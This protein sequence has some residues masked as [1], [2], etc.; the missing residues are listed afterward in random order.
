MDSVLRAFNICQIYVKKITFIY[1]MLI[2]ELKTDF[3]LNFYEK[4]IC[5]NKCIKLEFLDILPC[6]IVKGSLKLEIVSSF[7]R[8]IKV[9]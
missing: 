8:K 9:Y 5:K 4:L 7:R 2:I 3:L 6:L 1:F